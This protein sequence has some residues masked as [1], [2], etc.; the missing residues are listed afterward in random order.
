[1]AAIFSRASGSRARG[2][3][4]HSAGMPLPR[5][6]FA[7]VAAASA[8]APLGAAAA[9]RPVPPVEL[10]YNAYVLGFPAVS[11]DFHYDQ[12]ATGYRVM[13]EGR[14]NGLADLIAHYRMKSVSDGALVDSGYRPAEHE[15]TGTRSGKPWLMHIDFDG[16]SIRARTE[17]PDDHPLK[18]AELS[19]SIDPLTAILAASHH[20]AASGS[21][22]QR[23]RVFDGRERYD[24]VLGDEGEDIL[25]KGFGIFAGKAHRCRLALVKMKDSAPDPSQDLGRPAQIWFAPPAPDLP[26]VPVRV[27]FRTALG[28]VTVSLDAINLAAAP[29]SAAAA[30]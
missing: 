4:W 14:T 12:T 16:D 25:S 15:S 24:L 2:T 22:D 27:D 21:C 3:I 11:F 30:P 18:P 9:I 20:L 10:T 1:V 19:R 26:A 8:T 17:P 7:L 5:S 23:I 6:L 29:P 28:T 13:S